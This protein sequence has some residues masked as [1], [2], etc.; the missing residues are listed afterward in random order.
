MSP[1][2]EYH[3][4]ER[5]GIQLFDISSIKSTNNSDKI[6]IRKKT[7]I[8][9]TNYMLQYIKNEMNDGDIIVLD[10]DAYDIKTWKPLE[11]LYEKYG[12]QKI[13][14]YHRKEIYIKWKKIYLEEL[15]KYLTDF[16]SN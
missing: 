3:L 16:F 1:K 12:F 14:W 5:N 2:I 11:N 7:G 4:T 13:I 6:S 15:L 9:P 8:S 10:N